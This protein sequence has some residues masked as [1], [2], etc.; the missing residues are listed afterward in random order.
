MNSNED[1]EKFKIIIMMIKND[2]KV[3]DKIDEKIMIRKRNQTD[4]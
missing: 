2:E 4:N 3:D 1:V